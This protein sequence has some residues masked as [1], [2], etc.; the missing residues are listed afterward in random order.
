M[1]NCWMRTEDGWWIVQI[2]DCPV[3]DS[4][5]RKR[6]MLNANWESS[7]EVGLSRKSKR[8]GL[9]ANFTPMVTG[10]RCS[11]LRHVLRRPWSM[12]SSYQTLIALAAMFGFKIY[13]MDVKTR[14]FMENLMLRSI[15]NLRPDLTVR[16]E[17]S[18]VCSRLCMAWNKRQGY[19]KITKS[20]LL[21][22]LISL[23]SGSHHIIHASLYTPQRH[24]LL[25]SRLM[26]SWLV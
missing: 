25:K 15:S 19:G 23:D 2:I 21:P 4:F 1:S 17:R 12:P 13:L 7:P 24:Q 3:C 14:S 9:A 5:L 20:Y 22:L 18:F 16:R 26:I 10:L 8:L 11:T 6:T